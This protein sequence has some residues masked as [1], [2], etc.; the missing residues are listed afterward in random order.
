MNHALRFLGAAL[1]AT[2]VGC[3]STTFQPYETQ[4]NVYT[5][6]GGTK[7]VVDGID[8][9]ENGDPPRQFKILGV[10]DDD[11]PN[12]LITGM[13]LEGDI[14]AKA[15]AAGGDAV[16]LASSGSYTN[17]YYTSGSATSYGSTTYGSANTTAAH[18][19]TRKYIVVKYLD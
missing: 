12:G 17:G 15:T 18:R 16:I 19:N 10:I 6:S 13:M 9:W 14:A 8:F 3:S 1:L 2:L 7:I 11:R 4:S 5:G